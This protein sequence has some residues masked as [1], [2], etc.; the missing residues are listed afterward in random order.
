MANF[1]IFPDRDQFYAHLHEAISAG[2]DLPSFVASKMLGVE[3][4]HV[5]IAKWMRDLPQIYCEI[6]QGVEHWPE[7]DVETL[8]DISR[9]SED[10]VNARTEAGELIQQWFRTQ[11]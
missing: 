7:Y 1:N 2:L 3:Y 4:E 8:M 9:R 10:L 11:K 5:L 6:E